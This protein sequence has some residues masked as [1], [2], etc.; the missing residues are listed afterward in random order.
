M[1]EGLPITPKCKTVMEWEWKS[2]RFIHGI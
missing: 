2:I 1:N